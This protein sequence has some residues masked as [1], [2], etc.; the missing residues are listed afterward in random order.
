MLK[1]GECR[2]FLRLCFLKFQ[3]F[4]PS[5]S[6]IVLFCRVWVWCI[7]GFVMLY[8]THFFRISITVLFFHW[9]TFSYS[10]ILQLDKAVIGYAT[11]VSR[12]YF[13]LSS[14]QGFFF[15]L[16][17]TKHCSESLLSFN[18]SQSTSSA[19]VMVTVD[20][21]LGINLRVCLCLEFV[22]CQTNC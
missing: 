17:V 9:S 7:S 10:N 1:T 19:A 11:F 8:L 16:F 20:T 15:L 18:F 2:I 5:L 3:G 4:Q 21:R 6:V 22:R 12:L 13:L 14:S